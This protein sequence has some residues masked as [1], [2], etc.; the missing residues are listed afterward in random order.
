LVIE[1]PLACSSSLTL[2]FK[3]MTDKITIREA[4]IADITL[5][6]SIIRNSYQNV[7][8]RFGLTPENCLKHP[9]NCKDEWIRNDFAR[10]VRYYMLVNS[11]TAIG[12]VALDQADHELC[13]LER[14]AI[15]PE[16]RRK[17]LGKTLV[18]HV[19]IQARA[20]NAKKVSIGIISKQ[21]ELNA[22]YQKIGFVDGDTKEFPHLPFLV[23][24]MMYEL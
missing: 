24:F 22:W 1:T 23:T 10:G 9:S 18:D 6:S 2:A 15:L 21:T 12:C 8:E 13:Y 16:Y 14:L 20:L 7:A 11:G 4:N 3:I 19:F 17:G 5:L